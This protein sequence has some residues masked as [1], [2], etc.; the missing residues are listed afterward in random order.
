MTTAKRVIF[1]AIAFGVSM[2]S[3]ALLAKEQD[4]SDATDAGAPIGDH[5]RPSALRAQLTAGTKDKTASVAVDLFRLSSILSANEASTTVS[6]QSLE[7]VVSTPWDKE[8]DSLPASLDGLANGTKFTLTYSLLGSRRSALPDDLQVGL[9]DKSISKCLTDRGKKIGATP[10]NYQQKCLEE[11]SSV[12]AD[13]YLSGREER[14][15]AAG[16]YDSDL[17]TLGLTGSI[18]IND[19]EFADPSKFGLGIIEK[20]KD[21]KES[22]SA[23]LRYTRYFRGTPTAAT[24]GADYEKAWK[25]A[26]Q[27]PLCPQ[28]TGVA[29][30]TCTILANASPSVSKSFKLSANLRHR[31]FG[32]DGELTRFAL[33]PRLAFAAVKGK[34]D[35]FS[36]E[37]P[38]YFVPD[39]DGG[40]VGGLKLGYRS[41]T[42][43]VT[44]GIFFGAAFGVVN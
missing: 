24:I 35:V 29:V 30:Q 14:A 26:D 12:L 27:N 6:D 38:V 11:D 5:G 40:L 28:A 31:F 1:A 39:D 41:D 10:E 7:L 44:F 33:S 17:Q 37:L 36:A 13:H 43:D 2:P 16:F 18:A 19:F 8:N 23:G 21:R 9:Y 25:S 20:V 42:K 4:Y 15:L 34:K 22:W 32:S 3:Q